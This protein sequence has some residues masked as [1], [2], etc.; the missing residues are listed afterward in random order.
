MTISM[1]FSPFRFHQAGR[2]DDGIKKGLL[3]KILAALKQ[4]NREPGG[5]RFLKLILRLVI[6]RQ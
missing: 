2:L 4:R 5:P 1:M 6:S 3:G